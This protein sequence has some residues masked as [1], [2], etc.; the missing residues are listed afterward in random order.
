MHPFVRVIMIL[1]ASKENRR[2]LCHFHSSDFASS[3]TVDAAQYELCENHKKRYLGFIYS[4]PVPLVVARRA[5]NMSLSLNHSAAVKVPLP[6][7]H[8]TPE[9]VRNGQVSI[10]KHRFKYNFSVCVSPLFGS[11]LAKRLIEFLELTRLLGVHQV[12]FYDFQMSSVIKRVLRFYQD[13]GWVTLL[14]WRLPKTMDTAKIWYHGQLVTNNDCLYRSM[15]VSAYT[16]FHDIDE[17]I[18]PHA[19]GIK[20]LGELFPPVLPNDTCGYAFK[21]AFYDPGVTE[22]HFPEDLQSVALTARPAMLS[23][24]RTK[25][26]VAPRRVFEVGIHHISKQYEEHWL[27]K[28]YDPNL[29]YLHHYRDCIR[30]FGMR[31]ENWV[32]D[33][34]IKDKYLPELRDNFQEVLRTLGL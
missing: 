4:C 18:V 3:F 12:F 26:M 22:G 32:K 17:L 7:Q 2:A 28:Q 13:R 15:A 24:I 27:P 21:S 16:A 33:T 25:V 10:E 31:C 9:Q 34:T 6:V 14:P 1:S 29:A 11:V 8:V 23:R 20:S 19:Q 30:D 5:Y